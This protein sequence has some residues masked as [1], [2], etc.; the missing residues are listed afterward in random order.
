MLLVNIESLSLSELRSIAEQERIPE[1]DTLDRDTIIEE[2]RA[3]YEDEDD[4]SHQEE[5]A[6]TRYLSGITDFREISDFISELPGVVDLPD[7]YSD[8]EIHLAMRNC[9]WAYCYWTL[10][11]HVSESIAENGEPLFLSVSIMKNG[12]CESYEV[13]VTLSDS[14]WNISIPYGEGWA[15]VSIAAEIDG[16]KTILATSKRISLVSSYWLSHPEDMA[17]SD[18]LYRIYL[19][20]LT[21]KEGQLV[22]NPVVEDIVRLFRKEDLL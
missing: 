9:Q 7:N 8:T 20:M 22:E 5:D 10:S 1:A 3:I 11:H 6:N 21:T 12:E 13:P 15:E 2:L 14:E 16:K 19:S 18:S 17:K 4:R